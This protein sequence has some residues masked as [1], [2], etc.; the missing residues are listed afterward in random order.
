MAF[1]SQVP[2]EDLDECWTT[3]LEA[4][5][6]DRGRSEEC[7]HCLRGSAGPR[8]WSKSGARGLQVDRRWKDLDARARS[9]TGDRSERFSDSVGKSEYAVRGH[10]A[11]ASAYVEH[12]CA[13][14][15][16]GRRTVSDL[17]F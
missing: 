10:M 12:V 9:R 2:R 17:R 5:Q 8:L 13:D 7:K 6:S 4:D 16:T 14:R 15:G 3:G 1:K 11:D